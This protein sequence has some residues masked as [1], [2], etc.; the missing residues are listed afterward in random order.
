MHMVM[1]AGMH[2]GWLTYNVVQPSQWP[3][4]RERAVG[5]PEAA[6]EPSPAK[7]QQGCIHTVNVSPYYACMGFT[8]R[9]KMLIYL[10]ICTYL[11]ICRDVTKHTHINQQITNIHISVCKHLMMQTYIHV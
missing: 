6:A 11:Q 7:L 3:Q 4:A 10:C 5:L 8:A 1:H 2:T 9:K